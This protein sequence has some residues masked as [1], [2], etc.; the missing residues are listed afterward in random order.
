MDRPIAATGNE[1]EQDR[2][3]AQSQPLQKQEQPGRQEERPHIN[4]AEYN[5]GRRAEGQHY[6]EWMPKVADKAREILGTP[7]GVRD[8][9]VSAILVSIIKSE[10]NLSYWGLVKHFA[11]HPED[12]ERCELYRPYSR[13]QYQLHVSQ[14]KPKV[15]QKI[16]TWMAGEDAVHGTKIVDSSGY[17]IARY[18]DWYHTNMARSA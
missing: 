14:I 16:I 1:Q 13:A 17:S 10:E 2:K 8:W 18:V 12:L 3:E 6:T 4:W 7:Q 9:Q 5:R 11:K 15:Q